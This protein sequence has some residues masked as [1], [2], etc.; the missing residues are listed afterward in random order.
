MSRLGKA[1]VY[2]SSG[3]AVSSTTTYKSSPTHVS[4]D[5][6]NMGRI[7]WQVEVT[8]TPTGTMIVEVSNDNDQDISRGVDTWVQY[9]PVTVPGITGAVTFGITITP[10]YRRA[11]LSYTNASS[12]GTIKAKAVAS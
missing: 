5:R 1:D 10:G 8:G 4:L 3:T 9:T 2:G 11:R 7:S 12:S 6:G